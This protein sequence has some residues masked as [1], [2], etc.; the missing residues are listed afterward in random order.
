LLTAQQRRR[1]EH[2]VY[3]AP[4]SIFRPTVEPSDERSTVRIPVQHL[5]ERALAEVWRTAE[6][7]RR[8]HLASLPRELS[9]WSTYDLAHSVELADGCQ[10][11]FATAR[12]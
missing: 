3:R 8:R 5:V 11:L 4:Q 2:A 7:K 9:R 1:Q 10:R 6:P 12:R